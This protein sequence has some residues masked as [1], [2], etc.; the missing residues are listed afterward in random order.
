MTS[1]DDAYLTRYPQWADELRELLPA[2]AMMEE[3][4]LHKRGAHAITE[5][6]TIERL[7]DYR[8]ELARISHR[9]M[10]QGCLWERK[11]FICTTLLL[12]ARQPYDSRL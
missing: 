11:G 8:C 9:G 2:A 5:R 12:P 3:L 7:A 1:D 6:E 10:K 4:R